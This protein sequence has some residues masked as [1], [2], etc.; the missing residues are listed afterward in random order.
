MGEDRVCLWSG[1]SDE[2][3]TLGKWQRKNSTRR[4]FWRS[5][6][7]RVELRGRE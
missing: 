7:D 3:P 1:Q 6:T 2:D 5:V 4:A